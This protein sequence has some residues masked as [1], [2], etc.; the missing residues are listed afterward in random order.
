MEDESKP[1]QKRKLECLETKDIMPDTL[2]DKIHY[3]V[4]QEVM[5]KSV[6][7]DSNFI[8]LGEGFDKICHHF[9][10]ALKD[11]SNDNSSIKRFVDDIT[12]RILER[13]ADKTIMSV[14]GPMGSGKSST[15]FLWSEVRS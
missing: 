7:L 9:L 6:N 12:S 15:Y 3:D 5:S 1:G 10:D 11:P 8:K 13:K 2:P 4:T 14:N